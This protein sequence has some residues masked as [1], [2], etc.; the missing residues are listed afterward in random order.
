MLDSR[1]VTVVD[2]IA[3]TSV[4]RTLADLAAV[5]PRRELGN[6]LD[7]A[8]RLQLL[9]LARVDELLARSRGRLGAATLRAAIADWRPRNTRSELEDSHLELVSAA[10]LPDPEV[11]V[12]LD[13]ERGRHEV[14][15]LWRPGALVVQLDASP[16]IGPAAIG[17]ATPPRT[18]TS[19]S[20]AT[21]SYASPGTT[22]R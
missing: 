18:R 17:S 22:S 12:L 15:A 13:G 7:R 19:S 21:A 5:V 3:V 14:D 6:A 2:G 1:D 20:P 9:D 10:G 8:E 16:T 4:A 11:N